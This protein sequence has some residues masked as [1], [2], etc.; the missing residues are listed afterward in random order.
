MPDTTWP[1]DGHPPGASR[2]TTDRPGFDATSTSRHVISGSLTLA[3]GDPYLTHHV[4]LFLNAH[5]DGLQPTQLE[6]V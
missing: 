1:R 2:T 5:H 4:R 3:F 6:V